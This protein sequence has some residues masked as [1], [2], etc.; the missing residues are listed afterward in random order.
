M[1]EAKASGSVRID[2]AGGTIDLDPISLI[3]KDVITLNVASSLKAEVS[4]TASTAEV[5]KI[6]SLDYGKIYLFKKDDFVPENFYRHDMF[7]DHHFK[8]MLFVCALLQYF[9]VTNSVHLKMKS[10]SPP[11]AG[12]GGSSSLGIVLA[13]ALAAFSQKKLKNEDFLRIVKGTESKI[14]NQGVAGY[15]D[16]YPAMY[17]GILALKSK[18]DGV[19]VEQLYAPSLKKNLENHVALVYSGKS[20][21]SGINNWQVYKDFFD[22]NSQ[23]QDLLM[24]IAQISREA[25]EAAKGENFSRLVN[26]MVREGSVREKFSENILTPEMRSFQTDLKNQFGKT[27]GIKICGAGGGGC[28]LVMTPE[29][30]KANISALCDQ[31]AMKQLEFAIASPETGE[32]L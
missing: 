27:S 26:L 21:L 23:T 2:L 18:V 10:G 13:K 11:G 30:V 6:E 8:E 24:Q 3:L 1:K 4:I 12:L 14:L 29:H 32:V 28:F 15:Q 19:Q 20:R 7:S 22:K 17:G 31:Y 5:V 9:G 25:Y 16:Y